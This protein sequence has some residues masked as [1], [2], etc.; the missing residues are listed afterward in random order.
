[1]AVELSAED[2]TR[3]G[4]TGR[5]SRVAVLLATGVVAMALALSR[6]RLPQAQAYFDFADR[7][8]LAGVPNAMDV[9]SNL[10]FA[11]VGIA[12]LT[13]L[14]RGR[15]SLRDA[16]ERGPWAVF[17]AGVALTSVGSAWFHLGPAND[18]LVW[19]RVPMTVAFMGLLCALVA[20]RVSPA[21]GVRLL[22]PLVLAGAASVAWWIVTERAD[23]GDLRPYLLVQYYPLA[24]VLLVLALFPSRYGGAAGWVAGLGLYAG[25]KWAE[26]ADVPIFEAT[27]R[28]LSGHTLK[29]LLAAAGIAVLLAM[30]VRR[31]PRA[32]GR[33]QAGD[34]GVRAAGDPASRQA[35]ANPPART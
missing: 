5:T 32:P 16:R 24:C 21:W 11:V 20:E 26:V 22:G 18:S 34:E 25:A 7:R 6:K 27:G 1:M 17:F 28:A 23:A 9:L 12:G 14:R 8:M 10:A 33:V 3:P 31:R 4:R 29:H 2:E 30:L 35:Q 19:D 13:A 15:I